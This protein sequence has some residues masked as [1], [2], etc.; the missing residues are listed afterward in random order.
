MKSL[1]IPAYLNSCLQVT[2]SDVLHKMPPTHCTAFCIG[3]CKSHDLCMNPSLDSDNSD[4][5]NITVHVCMHLVMS[6]KIQ[7]G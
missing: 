4:T 3:D 1:I 7:I 2:F 5:A 6:T